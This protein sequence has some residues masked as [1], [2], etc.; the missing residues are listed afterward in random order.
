MATTNPWKQFQGLLPK[1]NRIIG[2]V[3]SHNNNGTSTLTLR[4]GS[5]LTIKSQIV[6]VGDRA[7]VENNN[8]VRTIPEL[9][10]LKMQV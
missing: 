9:P 6:A 8:I 10:V 5:L 2:T 3:V 4:D 1:A 7:L